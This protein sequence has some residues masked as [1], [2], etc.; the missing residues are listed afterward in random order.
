MPIWGCFQPPAFALL[1]GLNL[2][3]LQYFCLGLLLDDTRTALIDGRLREAVSGVTLRLRVLPLE[4][5][6]C[7]EWASRLADLHVWT[8]HQKASLRGARLFK[9]PATCDRNGDRAGLE[10]ADAKQLVPLRLVDVLCRCANRPGIKVMASPSGMSAKVTLHGSAHGLARAHWAF[11]GIEPLSVQ[12]AELAID[13]PETDEKG[14]SESAPS[15][16]QASPHFQ[17]PTSLALQSPLYV[18]VY[19]RTAPVPQGSVQ[20]CP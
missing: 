9:P 11:V 8:E 16:P 6:H 2:A 10:N 20:K 4:S 13:S 19:R 18:V 17:S 5:G 3:T 12:N 1:A 7:A 15:G 14:V